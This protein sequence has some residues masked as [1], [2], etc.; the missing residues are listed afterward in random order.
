MLFPSRYEGFGLPVVEARLSGMTVFA[1]AHVPVLEYLREDPGTVAIDFDAFDQ[2]RSGAQ[3]QAAYEI[4]LGSMGKAVEL[5][6]R[7]FFGWKRVIKEYC[8]LYETFG[9][10]IPLSPAGEQAR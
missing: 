6:D 2:T 4:F 5:A 1:S 8:A 10:E 3:R 7:N 9:F